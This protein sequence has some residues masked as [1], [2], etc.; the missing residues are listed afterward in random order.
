MPVASV[1][2]LRTRLSRLLL[3]VPRRQRGEAAGR[4]PTWLMRLCT[5]GPL[6]NLPGPRPPV[7]PGPP[8]APATPPLAP[9][10]A[11]PPSRRVGVG[12]SA[13][14][15]DLAEPPGRRADDR[16]RRPVVRPD[17]PTE[18]KLRAPLGVLGLVGR[19]RDDDHRQPVP[20]GRQHGVVPAVG[21]DKVAVRQEQSSG[22]RSARR[23]RG[24]AAVPAPPGRHADGDD[25]RAS[26]VR[27]P[28]STTAGARKRRGRECWWRRCRRWRRRQAGRGPGPSRAGAA[29]AAGQRS[30]TTV[31]RWCMVQG[32]VPPGP[33]RTAA[34]NA[35]SRQR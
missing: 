15:A 24:A 13:G 32:G 28:S 29:C 21:H 18:A 25:E 23:A 33:G 7:A 34:P 17:H 3:A 8:V 14:S 31:R 35:S 19:D 30:K 4:L 10:P 2:R 12:H 20:H 27:N 5:S 6:A 22:G 26:L 1:P 11:A 9:A 16:R